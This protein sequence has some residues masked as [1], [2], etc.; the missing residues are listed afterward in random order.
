[1]PLLGALAAVVM[2]LIALVL[3]G[4]AL[5]RRSRVSA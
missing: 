1:L 5:T 4:I 3:S 2:A